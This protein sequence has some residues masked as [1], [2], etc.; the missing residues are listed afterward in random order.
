VIGIS[1]WDAQAHYNIS[2]NVFL[3]N[4]YAAVID[5]SYNSSSFF[6]A[7]KVNIPAGILNTIQFSSRPY[8]YGLAPVTTVYGLISTSGN[9]QSNDFI[10]TSTANNIPPQT[11]VYHYGTPYK[12]FNFSG[13]T[14]SDLENGIR[15]YNDNY[16]STDGNS[17]ISSNI[18]TNNINSIGFEQ[19]PFTQGQLTE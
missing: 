13:N 5:N 9:V 10:G 1:G 15:V 6:T 11:G 12:E 2:N 19:N 14:L 4:R 17:T 16:L 7:N 3:N 18:F 8:P